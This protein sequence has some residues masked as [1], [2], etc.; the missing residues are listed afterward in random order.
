VRRTGPV[1]AC[2]LVLLAGCGSSTIRAH[3][4]E[5]TIAD[6][7]FEH[8]GFRPT[9]V[10]C[11]SGIPATVGRTFECHFTGPDGPYDAHVRITS[12]HGQR[13]IDHIVTRRSDG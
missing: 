1:I 3:A 11:P 4:T 2:F 8:T 13:V 9:D 10:R 12:V 6:F 7:V 5:Q